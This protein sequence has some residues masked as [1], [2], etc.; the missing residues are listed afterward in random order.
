M[1][2]GLKISRVEPD[3]MLNDLTIRLRILS[4][5]KQVISDLRQTQKET[6]ALAR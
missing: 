5:N 3:Y 1:Y 4:D 2:V 6:M